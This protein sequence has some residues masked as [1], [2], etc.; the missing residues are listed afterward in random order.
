MRN[1]F[2]AY[3]I[4]ASG[5][6]FAQNGSGAQDNVGGGYNRAPSLAALEK[7]AVKSQNEGDYFSAMQYYGRMLSADSLSTVALTGYGNNA[8]SFAAFERAEW[9]YQKMVDNNIGLADGSILLSLAETKVRLGKFAEAEQLYRRVLFT[10]K[11]AAATK[12]TFDMAQAGLENTIWAK[13]VANNTELETP[14]EAVT[15][16][17]TDYSEFAPIMVGDT[18]FFS[19]YRYPFDQDNHK[20]KRHLIKVLAATQPGDNWDVVPVDINETNRH[21]AQVAFNRENTVMYYTICEFTG[22]AAIRCD[23]YMRERKNKH[24]SWGAPIK[25]PEPINASGYTT[26]EPSVGYTPDKREVLYFASDRPGGK[27][28]RDLWYAEK[29]GLGF[30]APV[31]LSAINTPGDDVTPFYHTPSG[32]LYF[33]TNGL[34]TLGG[35]DIYSV[36]GYGNEWTEPRHLGMPIN[37]GGNDVYFTLTENEKSAFFSSNRKGAKNL[38][39]EACC[40]DIFRAELVKPQMISVFFHKI[41]GDSLPGVTVKLLEVLPDGKNEKASL[42]VPGFVQPFALMT[43]RSYVLVAS[44]PGFEPDTLPFLTPNI[45]W[46]D[47]LVKKLYLKPKT[48]NL[49][50]TVKDKDT[51]ENIN[52]ATCRFVDLGPV[53]PGGLVAKGAEKTT[54]D[55]HEK[56]NTYGYP[57]QF[58]HRYKVYISKAGYTMDSTYVTTE[59]MK[60]T[61]TI[62]KELFLRRGLNLIAHA[63]DYVS[64]DTLDGVTFKLVERPSET[65]TAQFLNRSGEKFLS[66]LPYEKTWLL[67]GTKP[68]YLPDSVAVSTV[69]LEKKPF[70]TLV[71]ELRL[72]P[73]ALEA[74]LPIK[75]YFDNDEPNKRTLALRTELEYRVTYVDYIRRKEDFIASY[76]AGMTGN[77]LRSETDS[78]EH[79]FEKEVR[80]GWDRLMAFS[81]VLYG[82]MS[83]GDKI[84]ITLRGFASPRAATSYN[85]NLTSRRVSSVWNH[86]DIFDGNI[87]RPFVN[88]GQLNI[89]FQPNG[90]KLAQ[91]GISDKIDDIRNSVINVGA[92]RERRLEIIGVKV[93]NEN[94]L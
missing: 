5:I 13:G 21:T 43:G 47:L 6:L 30:A 38:T 86:F 82:M 87:Y 52:A 76:T 23:I 91:P 7:Q 12:E 41:T 73:L 60:E 50:A 90:E 14:V 39:E 32:T 55:S 16:V 69:D 94:R 84:E 26:T 34:Q 93:N 63:L 53:L 72:R 51:G 42:F 67:Y 71:K 25:L 18:L 4:L 54:F 89:I 58:D 36:R 83:R 59:G 15:D 92:S 75:L 88:S 68:G 19:S 33:S 17:N 28:S 78:L 24:A 64:K 48:V 66:T 2:I 35:M 62:R 22:D 29:Q 1:L 65:T 27:G 81:E 74:Y 8:A 49:I 85:Q 9:A 45:V 80:G 10:E 40:F 20:P 46:R 3:F 37:S 79:F 77:Q 57:L 56:D 11:P 44:K 31:N 70:Q 61:Q